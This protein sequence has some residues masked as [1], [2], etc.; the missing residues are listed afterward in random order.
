[1]LEVFRGEAL[2]IEIDIE[3]KRIYVNDIP[4][5][6]PLKAAIALAFW[7]DEIE[8]GIMSL[9]SLVKSVPQKTP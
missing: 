1:M 7:S 9:L 4:Y 6:D 8:K 3:M 5:D 2:K